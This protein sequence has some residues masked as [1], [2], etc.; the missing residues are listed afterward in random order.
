[1]ED[2]TLT[3]LIALLAD[4]TG[5]ATDDITFTD[6]LADLGIDSLDFTQLI[7]EIEEHFEIEIPEETASRCLTVADLHQAI[8]F[9]RF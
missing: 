9:N 4:Y 2:D 1:M 3:N 7:L 6:T 5:I 8:I